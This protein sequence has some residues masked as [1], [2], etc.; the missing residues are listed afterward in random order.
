MHDLQRFVLA[1]SEE[2][3]RLLFILCFLYA[4][5]ICI[6][7]TGFSYF[8]KEVCTGVQSVCHRH[9]EVKSLVT[10]MIQPGNRSEPKAGFEHR[11]AALEE[12]ASPLS[13]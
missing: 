9:H 7:E 1:H 8:F 12:V 4:F 2:S 6:F 5:N 13:Q 11:R 3:D 10:G